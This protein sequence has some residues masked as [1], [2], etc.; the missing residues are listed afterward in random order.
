MDSN[1]SSSSTR[2]GGKGRKKG[3]GNGANNISEKIIEKCRAPRDKDWTRQE[4]GLL[5]ILVGERLKARN[6][7]SEGNLNPTA[8]EWN[9]IGSQFNYRNVQNKRQLEKLKN[10][11]KTLKADFSF[12]KELASRSG[13]G[14]NEVDGIPDVDPEAWDSYIEVCT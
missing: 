3:G 1:P 12:F 10:R 14:W 4:T 8:E 5:I 9:Y 13:H 7:K 11:W 2:V 6:N